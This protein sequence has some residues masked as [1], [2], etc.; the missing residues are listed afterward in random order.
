MFLSGRISLTYQVL[1]SENTISSQA[2]DYS[3]VNGSDR[4]QMKD[5]HLSRQ[6][7]S[8]YLS[9]FDVDIFVM[10]ESYPIRNKSENNNSPVVLLFT[11]C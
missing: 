1:V 11:L 3:L 2:V 8:P 7:L 4:W 10:F 5:G 6:S 9:I